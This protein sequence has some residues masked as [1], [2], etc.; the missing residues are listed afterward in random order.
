MSDPRLIGYEKEAEEFSDIDY[1]KMSLYVRESV[2]KAQALDPRDLHDWR[3]KMLA[4]DLQKRCKK[5]YS[6]SRYNDVCANLP[7]LKYYAS[8][9]LWYSD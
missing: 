2:I 7:P 3:A 1:P 4:D 8:T 5:R 6:N 9:E